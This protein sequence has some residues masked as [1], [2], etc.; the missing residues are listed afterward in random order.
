M[1]QRLKVNLKKNEFVAGRLID[2]YL[3]GEQH[4]YGKYSHEEDFDAL[5]QRTAS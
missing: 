3:Y 2:A 4:P 1:K 5:Q